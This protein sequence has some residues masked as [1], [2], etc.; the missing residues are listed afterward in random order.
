MP[1]PRRLC[2]REPS[3][4]THPVCGAVASKCKQD[5]SGGTAEKGPLSAGCGA[6]DP[7]TPDRRRDSGGPR[8]AGAIS[9]LA[10]STASAYALASTAPPDTVTGMAAN[11]DRAG[12]PVFLPVNASYVDA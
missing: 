11:G 12:P 3:T 9:R 10:R 7:T 4:F 2:S 1:V 5:A 8:I 6:A